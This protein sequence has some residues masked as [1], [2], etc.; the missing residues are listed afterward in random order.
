MAHL[1]LL[2]ILSCVVSSLKSRGLE[3]DTLRV[4]SI[5]GETDIVLIVCKIV[6]KKTI[7]S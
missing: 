3:F 4:F 5:V 7:L 6:K 1:K 2:L